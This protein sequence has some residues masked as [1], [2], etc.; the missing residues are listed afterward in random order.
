MTTE[1]GIGPTNFSIRFLG[2][3]PKVQ[4]NSGETDEIPR[5]ILG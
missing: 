5:C 2:Y 1:H 4:E 3:T